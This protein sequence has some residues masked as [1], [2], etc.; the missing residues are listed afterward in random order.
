MDAR[1]SPQNPERPPFLMHRGH[2]HAAVHRVQYAIIAKPQR[3]WNMAALA[4]VAHVT[5][6][7]LLRLFTDHANVSLLYYVQAIRLERSRQSLERGASVTQTA[8]LVGFRS[9]LQLRHAWMRQWRGLPRDA[10][11]KA[12]ALVFHNL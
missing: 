2:V 9:D 5:G 1:R 7:H 8:Q 3:D 10:L 12:R 11:R 4:Y 6:R